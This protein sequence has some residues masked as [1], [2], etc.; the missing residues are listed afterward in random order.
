MMSDTQYIFINIS[1]VNEGDEWKEREGIKS[2]QATQTYIDE[3]HFV[4]LS[5]IWWVGQRI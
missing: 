3:A 4:R 1:W 5:H 2:M